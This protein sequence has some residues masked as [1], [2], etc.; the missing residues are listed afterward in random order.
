MTRLARFA[1]VSMVVVSSLSA[2]EGALLLSPPRPVVGAPVIV[3]WTSAQ[4]MPASEGED[5]A[6]ALLMAEYQPGSQVSWR[7][8]VGR[9]SP[10]ADLRW[11]PRRAGLVRLQLRDESSGDLMASLDLG[12]RFQ[13]RSRGGLIVLVLAG[14]ILA[15]GVGIS[16]RNH[17]GPKEA[18][19]T[20]DRV[21]NRSSAG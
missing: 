12:V 1:V 19:G 7:E 18:A 15:S 21:T 6:S 9:W 8:T 11:T 5:V 2:S 17:L 20:A 16:L 13:G 10:G 3:K 4:G 14:L